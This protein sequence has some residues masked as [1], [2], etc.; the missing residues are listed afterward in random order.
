[1]RKNRNFER[2]IT[3]FIATFKINISVI[4]MPNI[5]RLM[6]NRTFGIT[7]RDFRRFFP[8]EL[9]TTVFTLIFLKTIFVFSK[10]IDIRRKT[11]RANNFFK[12]IYNYV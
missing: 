8:N 1:M 2:E 10:F 12:S 11:T 6:A 9:S 3:I 5:S 4:T 7:F